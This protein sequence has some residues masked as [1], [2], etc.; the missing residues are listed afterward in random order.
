MLIAALAFA[1]GVGVYLADRPPFQP[2]WR[3]PRVWPTGL[4]GFGVLGAWL[5]SFVHPFAF[6][7][8][9]AAALPAGATPRFGPCVLWTGVNLAFEWGQHPSIREWLAPVLHRVLDPVGLGKPL[10]NYVLRGTFDAGDLAAV[11][12]GGLAAAVLLRLTTLAE[13]RRHAH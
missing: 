7:L 12:L 4:P 6:S 5:P 9:T 10:A 2:Q 3:L 11:F 13:E 1:L 8:L